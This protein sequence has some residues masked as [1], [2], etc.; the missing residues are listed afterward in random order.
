MK[1]VILLVFCILPLWIMAQNTTPGKSELIDKEEYQ[2]L[3]ALLKPYEEQFDE[4]M[5]EFKAAKQSQKEDNNY[6][7]SI[8]DRHQVIIDNVNETLR[9]FIIS[10]PDSYISL[11]ALDQLIVPNQDISAIESLYHNISDQVKDSEMGKALASKIFLFKKTAIGSTALD[12]TQNDPEGNPVNLSD[13]RGKYVLID[14]WASW[15]GPCR[16]EN[17]VVVRAYDKF[18]NKNFEILGVSLDNG[19]AA[20]KSAITKDRLTWPQ[21]SDLRGWK[22][23]VAILYGIE[24]VP[25]NFLLDPE[26]KIIAKNLRGVELEA[27]LAEIL[28]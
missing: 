18:K 15:C 6:I 26:G 14:F 12:F 1:S 11:I 21:V 7:K 8:Q 3:E 17:P 27:K 24:S 10:H 4:L 19:K 5:S 23:E 16:K 25:Q 28:N 22:N 20:W 9:S 2:K 13:F